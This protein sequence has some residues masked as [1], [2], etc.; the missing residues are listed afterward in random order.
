VQPLNLLVFE[1]YTYNN[2]AVGLSNF[3][4]NFYDLILT[5][6]LMPDM[7]GFELSQKILQLDANVKVCFISAAEINIEALRE[8]HPNVSLDVL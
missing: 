5:D 4:P 6:I 7:N 3:K 8:V 1:V 2:P